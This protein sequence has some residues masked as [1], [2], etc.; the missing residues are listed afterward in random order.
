MENREVPL[1]YVLV[2]NTE[3]Q[4]R[5]DLNIQFLLDNYKHF[6]VM[7]QYYLDTYLLDHLNH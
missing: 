5:S 3:L 6:E 1:K 7:L 2:M 4:K